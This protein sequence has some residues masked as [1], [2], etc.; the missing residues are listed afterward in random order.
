MNSK[1]L[2]TAVQM[3]L[4]ESQYQDEF[5]RGSQFPWHR[6]HPGYYSNHGSYPTVC[7]DGRPL[8]Q[9]FQDIQDSLRIGRGVLISSEW[10][11]TKAGRVDFWIPDRKWAIKF[12]GNDQL[13]QY[14]SWFKRSG[15]CYGW[16][17]LS[18]GS[19]GLHLCGSQQQVNSRVQGN[20]Q[21][22]VNQSLTDARLQ[23]WWQLICGS[24]PAGCSYTT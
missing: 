19:V 15:N 8:E 11:R 4:V 1:T 23:Y 9:K 21:G 10:A 13:Q 24:T 14:L 6:W 2:S 17:R 7:S 22:I 12:L 18:W 20:I 3:R 5:Y 16:S